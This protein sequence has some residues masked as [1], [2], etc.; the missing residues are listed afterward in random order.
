MV[1]SNGQRKE[2]GRGMILWEKKQ[3]KERERK[4]QTARERKGKKKEGGK[5]R[6]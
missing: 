2:G 5:G 6:S 4:K 1:Q 3:K